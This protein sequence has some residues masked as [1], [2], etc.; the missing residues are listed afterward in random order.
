MHAGVA[1]FPGYGDC[2]ESPVSRCL[3]SYTG[4]LLFEQTAD[5]LSK[6]QK[7]NNIMQL[8]KDF[9]QMFCLILVIVDSAIL[10]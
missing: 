10:F 7:N 2:G 5:P 9:A 1:V 4:L 6:H 3:G 8:K